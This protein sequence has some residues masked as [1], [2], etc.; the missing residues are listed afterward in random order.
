M[1]FVCGKPSEQPI[2]REMI[3]RLIPV[4]IERIQFARGFKAGNWYP[5]SDDGDSAIR[6]A[7]TVTCVGAALERAMSESMVLNWKL[8]NVPRASVRNMWGVMPIRGAEFDCTILGSDQDESAE[9]VINVTNRIGRK[10]FDG[11]SCE[12]EPV[13]RLMWVHGGKDQT[14]VRIVFDRVSQEIGGADSI[15]IRTVTD[16][17]TGDDLTGQ[18]FLNLYPLLHEQEPWQDTGELDLS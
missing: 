4:P 1:L 16:M 12:P 13:Y 14:T 6:D 17:Q 7:K 5:F 8:T 2:I 3:E 18:V 15:T 11:V 10:M 9:V